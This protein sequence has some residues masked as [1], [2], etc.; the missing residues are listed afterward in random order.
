MN[1]LGFLTPLL[2]I[3]IPA[4]GQSEPTAAKSSSGRA[5]AE[6]VCSYI[7]GRIRSEVPQIPT[8]CAVK[9]ADSFVFELSVFSPTDVLEGKMRRAWSGALFEV[10]QDLFFRDALNGAC[11]P[12]PSSGQKSLEWLGC[13]VNVSDSF[14]SQRNTHYAIGPLDET[15][16]VL[17]GDPSSDQ[18]YLRWWDFLQESQG[19]EYPGSKEKAELLGK[20]ACESYLKTVLIGTPVPTCTLLLATDSDLYIV[21]DFP[22]FLEASVANNIWPLTK[23]FGKTLIHTRYKGAVVFR[24]PWFGPQPDQERVYSM[25]DVRWLTFLWAEIQSGVREPA[26]AAALVLVHQQEG[27]TRQRSFIP[28]SGGGAVL[29]LVPMTDGRTLMDLTD[30]SEWSVASDAASQCVTVGDRVIISLD[31]SPLLIAL[32]KALPKPGCPRDLKPVF[33]Q[34]W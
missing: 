30:G 4:F 9:R 20:D 24:S 21:V 1:L 8:S 10:L 18:W 6:E 22:N 29:K 33:V 3:T 15:L 32:P 12:S 34:G 27:Q 5:S 31:K 16:R 7:T 23:T 13:V 2:L 17:Y 28:G 19:F 25:F 26:Q 11:R 14:L